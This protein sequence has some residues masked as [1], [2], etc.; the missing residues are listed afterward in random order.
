[1]SSQIEVLYLASGERIVAEIIGESGGDGHPNRMLI[2]HPQIL[3][4][5]YQNGQ[6][7]F[8]PFM[9]EANYSEKDRREGIDIDSSWVCHRGP[10]SEEMQNAFREMTNPV[11]GPEKPQVIT[12]DQMTNGGENLRLSE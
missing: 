9:L 8:I 6:G 7:Q 12:P 2:R 11:K 4:M 5:N 3:I 1:M 10:A